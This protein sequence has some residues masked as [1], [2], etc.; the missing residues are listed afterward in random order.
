MLVDVIWT[1]CNY[2][3]LR[4]KKP[5]FWFYDNAFEVKVFTL[6]FKNRFLIS[7]KTEWSFVKNLQDADVFGRMTTL[8]NNWIISNVDLDCWE[9]FLLRN[10]NFTI[11]GSRANLSRQL[12]SEW[13]YWF[14]YVPRN[15][16]V[17]FDTTLSERVLK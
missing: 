14:T 10:W 8:T 12:W 5:I 16:A 3:I 9:R 7:L 1:E 15:A 11:Y 13:Y 17:L 2:I 4:L 6:S